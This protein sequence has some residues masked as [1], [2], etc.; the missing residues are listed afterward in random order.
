MWMKSQVIKI[1]FL[2]ILQ[3]I[4]LGNN[5]DDGLKLNFFFLTSWLMQCSCSLSLSLA[6][7]LS[8]YICI[9]IYI[10]IAFDM[11]S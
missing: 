1:F 6:F 4:I 10:F 11:K 9:Y 2:N 8:L 7:S 3:S 5:L